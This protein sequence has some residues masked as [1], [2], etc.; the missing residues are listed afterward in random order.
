VIGLVLLVILR[1]AA[2]K[3]P[4]VAIS[5]I[6]LAVS[7][8]LAIAF[9]FFIGGK[10]LLRIELPPGTELYGLRDIAFFLLLYF[11]GRASP[12]IVDDPNTLRRLYI[13]LVLT[14]AIAVVE[15]ILV[16]P[17]ML[18]LL[19]VASYFQDFLNVA[20]FTV[21]N[22]Y[23]L[24]MNYWTRI[25]NVEMQ[26]AGS[27]Y[28]SSQGFAVPFLILLPVATAYVFGQKR[29]TFSMKIEY[30][31][32]WLGLL[33]SITRMTILVC[34]IQLVLV[35]L[36]LRKPE[37][38]VAGLAVGCVAVVV[39]M[40]V[41]PGLPGFVWDTFTWQTGSSASHVKDWSKGLAAFFD[42]PW[43]A[44]LG[45]TDQSAVRFGLEPLTAD[46]GYL[47]YAVELGIQGLAALI[48]IFVGVLAASYK[49]ARY[50]STHARRLM[51]TV[52]L[53]TTIG[54]MLNATTGVVFNA[55][56]L[57]YL[58]FWFAGA[59]VTVAQQEFARAPQRERSSLELSP[60]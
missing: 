15:R 53:F 60:A 19:G 51:G 46:N 22:E 29:I 13:I 5:W 44:G 49:V 9:G 11:V 42:H 16:T 14:C 18:V 12:E 3:G 43:G 34:A 41:I 56:V 50:A 47:K 30:A 23:G 32:I 21:G 6:D 7:A 52:V 24:P 59:I 48:A 45:T 57:S 31:L 27:V 17:D 37:W 58:Y 2:G 10:T 20:A 39:S 4:R 8:L 54:I 38:A 1:A 25:G 35:I 33:L 40:F 55:L 28:L 26:R 36:M